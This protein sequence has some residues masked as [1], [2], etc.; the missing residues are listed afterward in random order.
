MRATSRDRVTKDDSDIRYRWIGR[1]TQHLRRELEEEGR[2]LV[3]EHGRLNERVEAAQKAADNHSLRVDKLDHL[4]KEIVWEEIDRGPLV[5]RIATLNDEIAGVDTPE[6]RK[7]REDLEA[8]Q[9][10]KRTADNAHEAL[11]R[12]LEEIDASWAALCDLEDGMNR[13]LEAN[14]PLTDDELALTASLPFKAPQDPATIDDSYRDAVRILGEQIGQHAKE[15][16]TLEGTLLVTLRAY[17]NIDERTAR[18]IDETIESL[19]A[20]L[21]ICEQLATDDLPRARERWLKKVDDDLNQALRTVLTQIDTDGREIRRGLGPINKM[22]GDVPFRQG[23]AL[24][25][26][27]VEQTNSDL[28]EFRD[29][30]TAY[31]RDTPLGVDLFNDDETVEASFRRLRGGLA[32]LSERSR[33]G[34]TWRKRVFDAREH[35]QFRAIETRPDGT[36]II[37]DGV[38]GMS[39]GEGQELIAFILGAA[40]RYRLGEGGE[41]L[42]VYGSVILDEGFVKADSDFTGRALGALQAL[43][44]QLIIGAPRE[45]ATAFEDFVDLVAYVN[46]DPASPDGVRIYSMTIEEAL[47]LVEDVA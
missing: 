5:L 4:G 15:R 46:T 10:D 44:F 43:G 36:E 23:S 26:E 16:D 38:S 14:A 2:K 11:T 47:Q 12:L 28:R 34:D 40:L 7:R 17:R 24:T 42:P 35:V 9:E 45:K 39:G 27:T 30:V 25:L 6:N 33:T 29:I 37:H 1:D 3:D 20:L 13:L 31:S 22:L 41:S 19:P 21:A 8:A 32:R 18:E